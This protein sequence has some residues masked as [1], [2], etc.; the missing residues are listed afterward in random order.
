MS[1]NS[2]WQPSQ[3]DSASI[4]KRYFSY[5]ISLSMTALSNK[6]S[7]DGRCELAGRTDLAMPSALNYGSMFSAETMTP[8]FNVATVS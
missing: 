6:G 7:T 1:S 2:D 3:L 8:A 4:A 5:S